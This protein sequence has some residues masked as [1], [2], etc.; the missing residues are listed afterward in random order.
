MKFLGYDCSVGV[1][2]I[3]IAL[4]CSACSSNTPDV[5]AIRQSE[6]IKTDAAR[7]VTVLTS[8][9]DSDRE[10]TPGSDRHGQT[11]P[12]ETIQ[13]GVLV[14]DS[15]VSVH[16]RYSP[17]LQ[18]LSDTTGYS[19]TLVPLFQTSQFEAA[20]ADSLHFILSNPL[21]SVKLQ[22]RYGTTFIAT[23]V[24]PQ[25]GSKFGGLIIVRQDSSIQSLD[26]LSG[27]RVACV[28][29]QTAAAGCV[30]QIYHLQQQG[31]EPQTDFAQFI[32]IPSQD[33]II[34][35]VLNG[36]IDAGFV[37]SGQLEQTS[38]KGLIDSTDAIRVLEP[39]SDNFFYPHTTP[40]YP[41]WPMSALKHTD[42]AIAEAV[43]EA[44]LNLPANHP[45]LS[46]AGLIGFVPASDYTSV[47]QLIEALDLPY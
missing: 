9:L 24:R 40:L 8:Q 30:F 14:I 46:S 38:A 13:V 15:A 29:F 27:K 22:Q 21:A 28:N 45:S 35:A 20:A 31:I 19:F 39:A 17:L 1:I 7:D 25:T 43:A 4:A 6:S 41:E 37:R 5:S 23:Q 26:D 12:S 44:L 3:A 16:Q 10:A 34:L 18:Y 33:N 47:S 42:P 2:G 32:E 11:A 36:T